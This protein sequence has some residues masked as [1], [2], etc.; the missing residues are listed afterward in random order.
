MSNPSV[1]DQ[2][3]IQ[4][5]PEL[6]RYD[7]LVKE[8]V[9]NKNLRDKFVQEPASVLVEMGFTK[10]KVE[11]SDISFANRLLLQL[12]TS[13]KL[14]KWMEENADKMILSKEDADLLAKKIGDR[15]ITV[16]KID[17]E[18]KVQMIK[19]VLVNEEFLRGLIRTL[20]EDTSIAKVLP[21]CWTKDTNIE[22]TEDRIIN[23]L[24]KVNNPQELR[25]LNNIQDKEREF[26]LPLIC[27]AAVAV[28]AETIV[29]A[30]AYV[31]VVQVAYAASAV[32][33]AIATSTRL[34]TR[35]GD[36]TLAYTVADLKFILN[37]VSLS[38]A[39]QTAIDSTNDNK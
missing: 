3:I 28:A 7:E 25:D 19:A 13:K 12:V 21:S 36:D 35:G 29:L 32:R 11:E 6:H 14:R 18:T 8:L 33:T 9:N 16:E 20:L 30:H 22:S 34:Y 4:I 37:A 24:K 1:V 26:C 17:D 23:A 27:I 5:R 31:G 10:E 39:L 38:D 2:L 15:E